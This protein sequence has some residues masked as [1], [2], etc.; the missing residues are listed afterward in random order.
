MRPEPEAP[1]RRGVMVS[2]RFGCV[3]QLVRPE[4]GLANALLVVGLEDVDG[5]GD[6]VATGTTVDVEAAEMNILAKVTKAVAESP[7]PVRSSL[8]RA[9][10]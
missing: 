3:R 9:C 1:W 2:H 10:F 5:F 7:V 8:K 4:W 6:E